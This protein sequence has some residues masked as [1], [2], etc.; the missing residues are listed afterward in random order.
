MAALRGAVARVANAPVDNRH[1]TCLAQSM[2]LARLVEAG[3]LARSDVEAAMT[4]AMVQA[5]K[6]AEEGAKI[7]AWALAHPSTAPLPE[8]IR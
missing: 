1:P 2:S 4:A 6:P 5:G 8:G 3:L 7:V